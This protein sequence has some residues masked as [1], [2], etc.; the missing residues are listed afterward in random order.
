MAVNKKPD[1][2]TGKILKQ[3]YDGKTDDLLTAG[4]G[5]DGLADTVAPS[6]ISRPGK[7]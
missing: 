3:I 7:S 6:G 2:I 5:K 4:L 1:F